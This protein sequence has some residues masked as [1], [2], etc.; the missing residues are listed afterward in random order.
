MFFFIM[1]A[2]IIY[3]TMG[4]MVDNQRTQ[5][6][7]LKAFGFSNLQVLFHYLSYSVLIGILGS[8]IGAVLGMYLGKAFTDLENSYF[9]LPVADMKM[10][11]ELVIPA[12]LL[13]L[14]FCLL[15]GYN[16]CKKGFRIMP[17][18]AMRPRAPLTGRKALIEKFV[19]L[20]ENLTYFWKIILRNVF[21][22]KRRALLTSTGVIFA[23]ALTFIAFGEMD[24]INYLIDQ[25][26]SNI[27]NYDIKVSF[28]GLLNMEELYDLKNIPHIVKL[29]PVIET[30]VEITNGWRKKDMAFTALTRN[31]EIYK[32]TDKDGNP[33]K[34]P[35][36]GILIPDKLAKTLA[37]KPGDT[38]T[39]KSYLPGKEKKEMQ[40]KGIIAQYIGSSVYSSMDSMNYLIGEG[41]I[42]NSAVIKLDSSIYEKEVSDRLNEMPGVSSVQS[43]SDSLGNLTKSMSSM[44]SFIGV[45]I[46]LAAGLSIAVIYNIATINIFER[47]RELATLKV[48]GFKDSEVRSLIFNENYLITSFGILIGLPFGKWLGSAMFSMYET[49][50]YNFVFIAGARAYLLAAVL[51]IGFTVLAN[52]ILMKK[53][54]TISMVEV[55]KSNE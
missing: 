5:I 2:V 43:K 13:T 12:A 53:I 37:V 47:Q 28:S 52:L 23:T 36:N 10:Y 24:S 22:N 33:V 1:A 49:D 4:R 17:S 26:Y 40:V 11:P 9:N 15:A 3:I 31:A 50:A 35:G 39:V 42:A 6:G 46:L 41:I 51:S 45:M 30:G 27:Q 8:A 54:R 20:W 48:L 7:V 18:E 44:T 29:E 25:Q 34:I 16:A 21:R 14:L 38:V 32:V 55:L 19:F